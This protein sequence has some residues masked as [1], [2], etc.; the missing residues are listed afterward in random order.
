MRK[1]LAMLASLSVLGTTLVLGSGGV[2]RAATSA[3]S[4]TAPQT[5][6]DTVLTPAQIWLIVRPDRRI[7]CSHASK[8]LARIQQAEASAAKR[9]TRWQAVASRADSTNGARRA[10]DKVSRLQKLEKAGTTL[11]QTIETTCK[12]SPTAS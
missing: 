11:E 7:L 4:G 12:V 2:A 5:S 1:R 10:T 3:P 6:H 9:L 8:E